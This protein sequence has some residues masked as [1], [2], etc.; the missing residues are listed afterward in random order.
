MATITAA[1]TKR[2]A[3]IPPSSLINVSLAELNHL[4]SC[5]AR[6]ASA[7]SAP[8]LAEQ[9]CPGFESASCQLL[10][11]SASVHQIAGYKPD[12]RLYGCVTV[13]RLPI[14]RGWAPQRVG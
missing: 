8:T 1:S 9:P 12:D 3:C 14:Q 5:N 11:P 6:W 13:A 4:C 7:R 10:R 2:K